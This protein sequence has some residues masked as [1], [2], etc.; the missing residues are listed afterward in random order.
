MPTARDGAVPWYRRSSGV[1]PRQDPRGAISV[2]IAAALN[3]VAGAVASARCMDDVLATIADRARWITGAEK[4]VAVLTD[5]TGDSLD[6]DTVVVRG[7][8]ARHLQGSG[9]LGPLRMQERVDQFGGW[10]AVESRPSEG[11]ARAVVRHTGS[12]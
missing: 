6:V 10:R 8:L 4:A 3:D 11:T 1:L 2:E 12:D 9:W 5:E 7:E